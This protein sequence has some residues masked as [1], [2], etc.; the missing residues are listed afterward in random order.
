MHALPIGL[1]LA[2]QLFTSPAA[3]QAS[4]H[5]EGEGFPITSSEDASSVVLLVNSEYVLWDRSGT[6]IPIESPGVANARVNGISPDGG[7]LVGGGYF[8]GGQLRAA[9]WTEQ[10]GWQSLGSSLVTSTGTVSTPNGVA[11]GVSRGGDS[12]VGGTYVNGFLRPFLWTAATG[13]VE[14]EGAAGLALAIS[15]DGQIISGLIAGELIRWNRSG[16]IIET[17]SSPTGLFAGLSPGGFSV[18]GQH[19]V[20]RGHS[21]GGF[22]WSSFTGILPV[23]DFNA[24]CPVTS[25]IGSIGL[26]LGG[27]MSSVS[28]S[29]RVA[30]GSWTWE[31]A[32]FEIAFFATIWTAGGDVRRLDEEL[33]LRGVDL[34]GDQLVTAS[35]ISSDGNVVIGTASDPTSGT[36]GWFW[37]ELDMNVGQT[38][39]LAAFPNSTGSTGKLAAQGSAILGEQNLTLEG[40]SLPA[41]ALALAISSRTITTG[42]PS[43]GVS[44]RLCL[45]GDIGRH[46]NAVR[47][48]GATGTV[49]I[50]IDLQAMPQPLGITI[51]AVVGE[52]WG[53]QIWHRELPSSQPS[54]MTEGVSVLLQ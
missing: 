3:A 35:R 34:N 14:L 8:S 52:T 10:G 40:T 37:A 9:Y 20:G 4:Y 50:P 12:I 30:V 44:I 16:D 43:T 27:T 29:G 36:G 25:P 18:D 5:F 53:F 46:L 24:C 42:F 38:F 48:T 31:P 32:L 19:V 33:E 47:M 21:V 28:E 45:A 13:M 23:G 15:A 2:A 1:F 49:S 41:N 6:T 22:A 11:Y 54:N 17:V 39:C 51:P 7:T 26:S